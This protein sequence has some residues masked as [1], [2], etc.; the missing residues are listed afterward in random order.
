MESM[1]VPEETER[2]FGKGKA[3]DTDEKPV[4]ESD[5]TH[6]MF[7]MEDGKIVFKG[8]ETEKKGD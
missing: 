5:E 3:H 4:E 7:A 8:L 2:T 1:A 6:R